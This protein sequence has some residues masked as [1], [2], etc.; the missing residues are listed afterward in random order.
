MNARI[1]VDGVF[2]QIGRT[3]IARVWTHVL[4]QWVASGIAEHV[5]VVDRTHTLPRIPG[6]TIVEAPA[7]DY[8][9][10]EGDRALLQR[11]CDMHKADVFI[12]TYYTYPLHTPS[13]MLVHDM[14]PE[15]MQWNLNV[16]MWQ[17]KQGAM[18]YAMAF[19][20]VSDHTVKDLRVYLKRP[21]LPVFVTYNGCSF[22]PSSTENI[23]AFR[24]KQNIT[25]PYF[26]LSGSRRGYK[27]ARLFFE[28]FAKLGEQRSQYTIFCTGGGELEPDFQDLAG[29][30]DIRVD[31]LDDQD[32][33]A[34]YSGATALIYPSRYE[35]FG[36]PVLEA[37]ACACPVICTDVASLPE[38][39]GNA[40]LY[41]HLDETAADQLAQHLHAVQDETVRSAMIA[42]GLQQAQ[43]F[44]WETM[45][46]GLAH[47]L[48]TTATAAKAANSQP[49]VKLLDTD[50]IVSGNG[51]R[52]ALPADHLLAQYQRNHPLYDRFL[53]VLAGM[54]PANSVA[55][56]VGANCGDTLA[57]MFDAN[58]ALHYVC[59]EP[60]STFFNYLKHNALH[61]QRAH[62]KAR[63]DLVQS[64]VGQSG[65]S[66][67][68]DGGGGSKHA[69]QVDATLDS[70]PTN[71]IH[72]SIPMDVI[73]SQILGNA[74]STVR[75][76]KSDVDGFDHDVLGSA[77]Q[78]ITTVKPILFFECQV[79]NQEQLLA[80]K[81]CI[82]SLFL[83]G[84]SGFWL[85]DNFGNPMFCAKHAQE[86]DQVLDYIWRQG[87][88]RATRTVYYVD[89][90]AV[91][92][93]DEA[94]AKN[95]I[96]AYVKRYADA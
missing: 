29:S 19:A 38:V 67:V 8:G 68:L 34:A 71:E 70:T 25:K 86:I 27:N 87:R 9:D 28:A 18:N 55:I 5:L 59:V 22:S 62:P 17:Q 40:P 90:L 3:G 42:R 78:L 11:I 33:M 76:L 53:P 6:L 21:D 79:S 69:R 45:A 48:Q 84:Y 81:A 64:L 20:A 94:L 65:H 10:L 7:F 46:Q 51:Y 31:I 77:T 26:L 4:Q 52:F 1:V 57:A 43:R 82:N 50:Q 35:G 60:D 12:S 96:D 66:A 24:Q 58:P 91:T 88:Q 44:K 30:A 14:I 16:P 13:L 2:F 61:I 74:Q 54:L 36:L 49:S 63:I 75:L 15:V 73:A 72:Q 47:A 92:P 39:G 37:M 83:H 32:M 95:A 93:Y 41:V 23:A 85:F 56:D 80:Y 89:I